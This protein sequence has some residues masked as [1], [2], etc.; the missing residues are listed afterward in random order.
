MSSWFAVR[1]VIQNGRFFEERIT[2]W[3]AVGFDAAIEAARKEAEAYCALDESWVLLD[4]FQAYSL[5]GKRPDAGSEVF[6]LI[7]ESE[8]NSHDYI[9]RFFATRTELQEEI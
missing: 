4:L 5:D 2:L 3:H 8:L 7:R 9:E 6:S 1:H